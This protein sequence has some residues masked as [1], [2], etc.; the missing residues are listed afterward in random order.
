MSD[1][2]AVVAPYTRTKAELSITEHS[3]LSDLRFCSYSRQGWN[4][5]Y[6]EQGTG[7]C[8]QFRPVIATR[9]EVAVAVQ[10]H[11]N[12][13]MTQQLLHDFRL[14]FPTAG[15]PGVDAP[16]GEEVPEGMEDIF[17]FLHRLALALTRHCDARPAQER[18]VVLN[19]S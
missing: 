10:R 6:L 8:R 3:P 11:D 12:R 2:Q 1:V 15:L 16:G 17:G 19:Q 18:G 5:C 9:E 14:Q 7:R 13:R 4:C